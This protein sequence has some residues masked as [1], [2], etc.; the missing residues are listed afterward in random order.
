MNNL[1]NSVTDKPSLHWNKSYYNK[2][3]KLTNKNSKIN[4]SPSATVYDKMPS[5]YE[6]SWLDFLPSFIGWCHA[7][8]NLAYTYGMIKSTTIFNKELYKRYKNKLMFCILGHFITCPVLILMVLLFTPLIDVKPDIYF[9]TMNN[10]FASLSDVTIAAWS[11]NI[12]KPFFNGMGWWVALLM[13]TFIPCLNI[14]T[15]IN[16][17]LIGI[18]DDKFMKVIFLENE[19]KMKISNFQ[20]P[21]QDR[22]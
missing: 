16:Y 18:V 20:K 6:I 8:F 14:S 21:K 4:F 7:L 19:L 2:V 5:F 1:N 11:E 15:F 10:L 9:S 12:V 3:I 17:L 22:K 13:L